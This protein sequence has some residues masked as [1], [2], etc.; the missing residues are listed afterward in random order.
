[1]SVSVGNDAADSAR[2]RQALA[3]LEAFSRSQEPG[4]WPHLDK[5]EII[6]EMRSHL[7]NP[8]TVNQGQQ[9]FCGPA[10]ILFELIRKLPQRYVTLT[11]ALFET[12]GFQGH[13]RQIQ[14][15]EALR[16]ASQGNLR[17]GPADWMILAT[18]RESEN[19]IFPVEPNAPEIV[20]NLAGMTK[21]WEMK[22]WVREILGYRH[23]DY[24]HTYVLRDLSALRHSQEVLNRGGVAF[25]LI[26]ASTLLT[27]KPAKIAVPE[28]WIAIVGNVSIQKG[29]FGRHDS[30]H[31]SFDCFTWAKRMTVDADEGPFED[32]FWGVVLGWN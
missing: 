17:M 20:R 29:S 26:T 32:A 2:H 9:P 23:V 31:V 30:G 19:L 22:G 16:Q 3:D 11:R 5:A 18:L 10:S 6:A 28:H 13:S 8:F 21:S 4:V 1:M 7:R 24:R 27:D 15:S 12:G 25:G 14:T